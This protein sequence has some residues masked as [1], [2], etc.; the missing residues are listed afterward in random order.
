M[1][2][3]SDKWV[4]SLSWTFLSKSYCPVVLDFGF[5]ETLGEALTK[6]GREN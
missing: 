6:S 2:G 1:A 3:L 4:G 5:W